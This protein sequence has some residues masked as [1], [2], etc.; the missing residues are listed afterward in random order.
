MVARAGAAAGWGAA[1]HKP[2]RLS[3]A[4]RLSGEAG[5]L[6]K[7]RAPRAMTRAWASG[8]MSPETT[9]TLLRSPSRLRVSSTP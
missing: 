1:C 6:M 4:S 9:I 3:R 5:F 2:W 7:S 8:W